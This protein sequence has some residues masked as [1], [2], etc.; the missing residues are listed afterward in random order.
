MNS[1]DVKIALENN[2]R[3]NKS[4]LLKKTCFDNK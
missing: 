2:F 1:A 4:P 3:I